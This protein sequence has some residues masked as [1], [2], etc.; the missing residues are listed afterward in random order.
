MLF[1]SAARIPAENF[2][3]EGTQDIVNTT[4]KGFFFLDMQK[5]CIFIVNRD[6][7]VYYLVGNHTQASCDLQTTN[8]GSPPVISYV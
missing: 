4:K 2:H 5:S 8:F 3:R 7:S 6:F 1:D